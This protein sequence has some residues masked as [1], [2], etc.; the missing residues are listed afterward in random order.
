MTIPINGSFKEDCEA[1]PEKRASV[2]CRLRAG[3]TYQKTMKRIFA[4]FALVVLSAGVA[5]AGERPGLRYSGYSGGMALHAGYVS[6]GTVMFTGAGG[7][8]YPQ[9][10]KGMT[11]GIGGAIRVHL[12]DYLRVGSEGYVTQLS[13]GPYDSYVDIGWGGV[14]VDCI[15]NRGKFSPFA[16]VTLGG[17]SVKHLTM[18]SGTLDDFITEP[19]ISFR[20]YG[21]MAVVPFAGVEYAAGRRIRLYL[22]ADYMICVSR[23]MPDFPS[24]PRFYV[25]LSFYHGRR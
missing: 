18:M 8:Q 12:G 13:Y 21:F 7:A 4:L 19:A 23:R 3:F 17:G 9:A 16:G 24:G 22:K 10:V 15:W 25:G 2:R 20:K 11:S 1:N 5:F 6:A 14:L